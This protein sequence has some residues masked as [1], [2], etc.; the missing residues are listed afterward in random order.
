LTYKIVVGTVRR[1]K[2]RM[3]SRM[4]MM[5]SMS[6]LLSGKLKILLGMH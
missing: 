6:R 1:K 3:R 5:R 2:R 4:K